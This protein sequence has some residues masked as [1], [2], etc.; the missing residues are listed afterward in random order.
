MD[1]KVWFEL[2]NEI[3]LHEESFVLYPKMWD[4]YGPPIGLTWSKVEFVEAARSSLP[5]SGGLYAF[6][7]RAPNPDFPPNSYLFYIGEVGATGSASRTFPTRFNEYLRE[8][9]I[10]TRPK[11]GY[12]LHKF[13]GYIDFYYC[14]IDH[15]TVDIKALES[16]L[17]T[18]LWP[19]ANVKDFDASIRPARAAF[20]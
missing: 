14:P 20:S 17:I 16:R 3:K 11:V 4:R 6:A 10:M 1:T 12:Y 5:Q 7:I 9:R 18:S 19:K 13:Y 8:L 2:V 15:S